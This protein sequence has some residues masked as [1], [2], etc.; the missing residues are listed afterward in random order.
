MLVTSNLNSAHASRLEM[1]GLPTSDAGP[2]APKNDGLRPPNG[3][4]L[5]SLG[6]RRTAEKISDN[7][8]FNVFNHLPTHVVEN[9]YN[10]IGGNW[11]DTK[12]SAN[13][14]A[15]FARKAEHVLNYI[16]KA[17]GRNGTP[18]NK[19]IDGIELYMAGL[20][21]TARGVTETQR[22]LNFTDHGYPGLSFETRRY[23]RNA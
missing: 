21:H 1:P 16:D 11:N 15:S 20:T 19:K 2:R 22:L 6:D 8:L 12:F 17:G 14:R 5:S 4:E 18:N 7:P 13:A 10:Q 23:P 9:F 3:N